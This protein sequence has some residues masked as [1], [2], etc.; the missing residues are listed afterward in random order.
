MSMDWD[1]PEGK[2]AN[3]RLNSLLAHIDKVAAREGQV[4]TPIPLGK[5]ESGEPFG[6]IVWRKPT[7]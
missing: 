2:E 3:E 5:D 6:I 1:S 4:R 7:E